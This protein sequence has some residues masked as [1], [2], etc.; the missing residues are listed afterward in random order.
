M[1][2]ANMPGLVLWNDWVCGVKW[3]GAVLASMMLA[4]CAA[5]TPMMASAPVAGEIRPAPRGQERLKEAAKLGF[6]HAIVPKANATMVA[7]ATVAM[8]DGLWRVRS[9]ISVGGVWVCRAGA[10][11]DDRESVDMSG[12]EVVVTA[13]LK[14]GSAMATIWTNDLTADY[15][16]ENSA[17][18][19]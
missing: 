6:T 19:S 10:V 5:S 12:R 15:V 4:G 1:R 17:Y 7:G 8:F 2:S 14:S 9:V 13:D 11:G 3:V 16:H 18:S